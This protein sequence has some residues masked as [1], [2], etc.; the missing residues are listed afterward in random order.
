[1]EEKSFGFGIS[2]F[3][4]LCFTCY[5]SFH[6]NVWKWKHPFFLF[7][8]EDGFYASRYDGMIDGLLVFLY[9]T[10]FDCKILRHGKLGTKKAD[11]VR[12]L[13]IL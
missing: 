13:M 6:C 7:W 10:L 1:M 4:S 2:V 9:I 8:V 5:F 11:Q 12:Q 3:V